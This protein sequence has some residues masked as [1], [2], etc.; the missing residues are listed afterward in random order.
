MH[1]SED[2]FVYSAPSNKPDP[3]IINAHIVE[4]ALNTPMILIKSS[5]PE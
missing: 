3:L 4:A 2:I 1:K 5:V